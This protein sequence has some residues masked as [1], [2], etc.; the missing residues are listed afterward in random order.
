MLRVQMIGLAI[1]AVLVM[2]AVA[3]S[4]VSAAEGHL[5]LLGGKLIASP[6][7]THSLGLILLTDENPLGMASL[8][9]AIHCKT[10][11]TRT[12]GAHRLGLVEKLTAELLGTN[13]KITCTF[14]KAGACESSPAPLFLAVNLPWHTE[15]YLLGTEVRYMIASEG[16]GE[17]GWRV[18]CKAPLLGTITDE[19][20]VPLASTGLSNV[21]GGVEAIF[22]AKTEQPNC[23]IG[24]EAVRNSA[25]LVRGPILM[26]SPSAG[27]KLTFD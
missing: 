24:T 5:W 10:F 7:K 3:A 15:L 22:D 16:A 1:V 20:K 23:K 13:D 4:S 11:G 9:T 8:K 19:C 17:P 21:A 12:V 25:G 18:I 6:V 2:S 14:D 27:E 26:E